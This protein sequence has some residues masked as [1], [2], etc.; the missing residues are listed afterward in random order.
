[1]IKS[2]LKLAT[3]K[4]PP[5]KAKKNKKP[6][7][8]DVSLHYVCVFSCDHHFLHENSFYLRICRFSVKNANQP[9]PSIRYYLPIYD[10]IPGKKGDRSKVLRELF[11]SNID[12]DNVKKRTKIR[13]IQTEEKNKTKSRQSRSHRNTW[14]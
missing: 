1:V 5:K 13:T 8:M 14:K 7:S 11:A 12:K 4:E 10:T 6:T 3:V 9:E 2:I